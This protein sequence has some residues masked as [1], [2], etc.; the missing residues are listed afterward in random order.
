MTGMNSATP[1][2]SSASN[3]LPE[4]TRVP[5]SL[6]EIFIAFTLL[7]LQGFGGVLAISQTVIVEQKRWLT[8]EEYVEA[9]ALC[10]LLPG[11]SMCNLALIVG[12]RFFGWRGAMAAL[13][14]LM[15]VPL[16][17]VLAF[18]VLYARFAEVPA[19]SATLRGMGAVSAGFIIGTALK[20]TAALR[21][22]PLRVRGCALLIALT[23]VMVALLRWPLAW[24]FPGIG[25]LA[26]ALAWR[27]LR[28]EFAP[29]PPRERN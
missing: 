8:L 21:D 17:I 12:R 14:G 2:S 29:A 10:Q 19:V 25:I 1:V 13:T 28:N 18:T 15:A 26:Y 3:A 9:L 27:A 20:L 7:A 16:A 11:A 6:A 24:V 22:N 23:F 4:A 5:A